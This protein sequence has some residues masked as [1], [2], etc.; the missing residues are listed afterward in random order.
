[1]ARST[2]RDEQLFDEIAGYPRAILAYVDETGYPVNIATAFEGDRERRVIKLTRPAG[3][4]APAPGSEVNVTFSHIRPYPGVGYDQRRYVSIWGEVV[5]SNGAIEVRPVRSHGW[6]EERMSFFEL[7]ER[8]VPVAKR[9]MANLSAERGERVGPSLSL[10]WR[11]F[12]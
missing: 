2:V 6:D 9:Y 8:S 3:A 5:A 7:C 1:M 12:L 4:V 11:F 10:A